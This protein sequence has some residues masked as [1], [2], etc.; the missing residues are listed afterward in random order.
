M[1]ENVI[2]DLTAQGLEVVRRDGRYFVRCDA[3][4]HQVAWREVELTEEEFGRFRL[5]RQDERTDFLGVHR[6]ICA[7]GSDP[8][9]KTGPRPEGAKRPGAA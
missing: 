9:Q 6:Q 1:E 4:V 8:Y 3:G 2:G 7:S 5:G